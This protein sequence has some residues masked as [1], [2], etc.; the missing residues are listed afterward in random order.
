MEKA[1]GLHQLAE[2]LRLQQTAAKQSLPGLSDTCA[3]LSSIKNASANDNQKSHLQRLIETAEAGGSPTSIPSPP[4]ASVTHVPPSDQG[5]AEQLRS[6]ELQIESEKTLRGKILEAE[7]ANELHIKAKQASKDKVALEKATQAS[8][9]AAAKGL[10]DQISKA[11]FVNTELENLRKNI[12][13]AEGLGDNDDQWA[14]ETA[15]PAIPGADALAGSGLDFILAQ[16]NQATWSN[17]QQYPQQPATAPLSP[18]TTAISRLEDAVPLEDRIKKL[19]ARL[20]TV[21]HTDQSHGDR[22]EAIE[23]RVALSGCR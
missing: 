21:E 18:A 19:H 10:T 12:A 17:L 9:G 20:D 11:T 23:R 6:I 13:W 8:G 5:F 1:E 3:L 22:L 14:K 4:P 7:R 16:M 2:Q 15:A